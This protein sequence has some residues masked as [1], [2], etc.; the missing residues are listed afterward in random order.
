MTGAAF[1]DA[2]LSMWVKAAG[3]TLTVAFGLVAG[4]R[5]Q[6]VLRAY[7]PNMP[8]ELGPAVGLIASVTWLL[9]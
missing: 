5:V 9:L 7:I 6:R 3:V 2:D 1:L 8:A 4:Y